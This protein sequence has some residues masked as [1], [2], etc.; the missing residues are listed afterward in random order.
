M[1]FYPKPYTKTEVEKLIH[2][3]IKL[4]E[5]DK[6]GFVGV[7][8]KK[9]KK[10][11]GNCGITIQN[12]DGVDEYE[13]GYHIHI[14]FWNKGFATEAARSVMEYGFNYLKL[15]K[16]CS[17]MAEDHSASRKV[18]EKIGMTLEKIYNNPNNRKFPTTVYSKL[19]PETHS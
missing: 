12:I 5:S 11:I 2:K 3:C 13:I 19:N 7:F 8:L 6:I 17:Y 4:Y 15:E 16:L 14:D 18:A 9:T 1:T 10:L